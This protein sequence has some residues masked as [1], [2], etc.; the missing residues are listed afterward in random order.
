[1]KNIVI[2]IMVLCFGLYGCAATLSSMPANPELIIKLK[3]DAKT[4]AEMSPFIA[5]YLEERLK[6]HIP[7]ISMNY[8]KEIKILVN[9]ENLSDEELALVSAKW[10]LFLES[11]SPQIV[12]QILLLLAK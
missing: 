3:A 2:T 10:D 8:L 4:L 7:Q 1:M 5:S 9:K 6:P 12:E 11:V